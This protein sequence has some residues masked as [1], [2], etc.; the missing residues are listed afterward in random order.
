M[1]MPQRGELV[2]LRPETRRRARRPPLYRV[3]LHN[4]D[5]TPREFVVL[6]LQRIFGKQPAEAHQIMV[7]A[8]RL[9]AARVACYPREVAEVKVD[10]AMQVARAAEVPLQFTME[11]DVDPD[12]EGGDSPPAG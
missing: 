5:Y 2:L 4:D 9:G 8:H 10:D 11:P 1:E 12:G 3:L 7:H 6:V